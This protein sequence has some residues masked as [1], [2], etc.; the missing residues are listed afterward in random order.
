M[1][2]VGVDLESEFEGQSEEHDGVG[3]ELGGEKRLKVKWWFITIS[4]P[5]S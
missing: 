5:L 2:E 1:E 4:A 3:G